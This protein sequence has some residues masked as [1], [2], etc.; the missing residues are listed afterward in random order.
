VEPEIEPMSRAAPAAE[1]TSSPERDAAR[2]IFEAKEVEYNPKRNFH[3]T[4][5]VLLAAGAG[6]GGYVWWQLQPTSAVDT[7]KSTPAPAATVSQAPIAAAQPQPASPTPQAPQPP[8]AATPVTPT[9]AAE[10]AGTPIVPDEARSAAR[11]PIFARRNIGAAAAEAANATAVARS[12]VTEPGPARGEQSP[13]NVTPPALAVDPLV[14]R[15]FESYQR[16]DLAGAREAYQQALRREPLN[17]DALLGLAAIDVHSRSYETAEARYARLLELDPRDVYA[18]AGLMALRGQGDPVQSESRIKTLIAANPNAAGLHFAL[19][20]LYAQQSRWAEAQA[21]YFKAYSGDADNADYAFNLAVSL[22]QLR[23][24][25]L[26]L[27]YYHR[28]VVL[29]ANRPVSFELSQIHTRI[30]ELQRP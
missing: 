12:R 27:Q 15:G 16:G 10:A 23:Q 13:I 2:Q 21:A 29:A 3:I 6:Y 7:A 17:R 22:D 24:K 25:A 1:S 30:Q 4:I 26:A 5:G 20:N 14:E 28:A 19:G 18:Q 9:A 8:V 11:R